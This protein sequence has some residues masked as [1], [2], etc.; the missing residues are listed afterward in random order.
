MKATVLEATETSVRHLKVHRCEDAT[1]T[2]I[3]HLKVHRHEDAT[4][5]DVRTT[6]QSAQM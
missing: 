3:R 6:S 2:G 1:E 5:T 4:E